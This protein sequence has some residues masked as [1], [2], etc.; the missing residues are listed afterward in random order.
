MRRLWLVFA[1]AVV[2]SPAATLASGGKRT[3]LVLRGTDSQNLRPFTLSRD[4]NIVWRCPG[5][6]DSNFIFSTNQDIPVNALGPTSGRS[7][8]KKGRYTRVSVSGSGAWTIT[9][10]AA[11]ARPVRSSYILKGEDG[12]NVAPFTL[13]HGSNIVWSCPR[14]AGSNFIVSTDQDI[15]VN[16]LGP[17]HGSS[18]LERGRYTGVSVTASGPWT[19]TIR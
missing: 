9:L 7:F 15:P 2:A 3:A 8:L 6:T 14:C 17:T 4:S 18:F 16:A 12:M 19:I 5:C 13:T 11:A 10:T 1:I